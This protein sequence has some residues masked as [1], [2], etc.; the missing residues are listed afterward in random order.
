MNHIYTAYNSPL[1]LFPSFLTFLFLGSVVA[2]HFPSPPKENLVGSLVMQLFQGHPI[3]NSYTRDLPESGQR[4][5]SPYAMD[6][7]VLGTQDV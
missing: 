1:P 2:A 7:L 6:A 4:S 3:N 5:I